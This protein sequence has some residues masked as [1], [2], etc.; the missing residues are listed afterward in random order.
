MSTTP[1]A[2]TAQAEVQAEDGQSLHDQLSPAQ[3]ARLERA[4]EAR[5]EPET[6]TETP[7]E[8]IDKAAD[9]QKL[10]G[11][12]YASAMD[13]FLSE[14]PEQIATH[15]FQLNVGTG[16]A[17]KWV[18][19]TVQAVDRDEIR[20]IRRAATS[21]AGEMNE[22]EV[23]TRIAAVGTLEPDLAVAARTMGFAD[24]ADALKERFRFKPGLIDQIS[25][26]VQR[27]S[28]YDDD[29]VREAAA[30]REVRA[31]GN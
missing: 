22:I 24:P 31:A 12:E 21:R 20:R 3:Q 19:W 28:G 7:D 11:Q 10:S 30:V 9:G 14:E 27:T 8:A 15:T 5:K 1:S 13:W 2:D 23:S 25:A 29:D 16:D 4:R 17:E 6:T 18:P 26:E